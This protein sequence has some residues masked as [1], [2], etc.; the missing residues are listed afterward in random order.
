MQTSRGKS[1]PLG[2]SIG[3]DGVNFSVF[4]KHATAVELLLFDRIGDA[5]PSSVIPL[6]RHVNRTSDYW[7][8]CASGLSA[9]QLYGY[10]V[11]GP[12]DPE[13]GLRYDP[14][15]LLLD[16]YGMSVAC[17][18]AYSRSAASQPGPDFA[19]AMKSVVADMT[20]YDWRGDM[21]PAVPFQE[22]VIYEM[23]VAGFTKHPNSGVSPAKRGTYAGVIEKIP[24]LK[25]LGVTAVELL[26]VFQFDPQ[27]APDHLPNYWG[28]SPA[29]F[30]ALHTGYCS[31]NDPLV[32]LDEF[33]DMVRA[34]HSAGLEVIL[35]VVY[36]HTAEGGEDGPTLCFR[37]IENEVY[38][39]LERDMQHY[40][41]YTGCG[42]TLNANQAI[43]RRMIADS[44]KYW[45]EHM[46]IDGFRFDLAS[47]L[48]RDEDGT[49]LSGAPILADLDSDP[50]LAETK[51]IAEAW[52]AAGLYEVGRLKGD[53]WKEWNGK[54]RDDV[55]RFWKSDWDT[56]MLLPNRVLGS[57]DLY[58]HKPKECEKSINF[59]T[60]HDGFTL[61]DLVSYNEKHNEANLQNNLD[62]SNENYSWNCGAEGPTDNPETENLRNRQ[63]R[64]FFAFTLLSI[65]VPMF[66]MGDEVRRTQR[67]NNNPFCQDNEISWFDWTLV[68]KYADLR[69]FVNRLIELRRCFA[70]DSSQSDVNLTDFLSHAQLQWHG[71]RLNRPDW[72]EASH[73]LAMSAKNISCQRSVHFIWNAYWEPLTFELPEL[74]PIAHAK[75]SRLIDTSLAPPDDICLETGN[76]V[77]GETYQAAPRSTVLLVWD[78]PKDGRA[79]AGD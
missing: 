15:K 12:F 24:Y 55:R 8:M 9:G 32:C 5:T 65:G 44:V 60:C 34:L 10:R 30:F 61:N 43:V 31:K 29:S 28:Y 36:N 40:S 17:D 64:N 72:G 3:P 74:P 79:P 71:I 20:V 50:V 7:H 69:R 67:G 11:F 33:R 63:V 68:E 59:I 6:D 25:S 47:I 1:F 21:R 14:A 42:N 19:N 13:H 23:H 76:L 75:W 48:S 56:A 46:H 41:D 78:A 22:T 58:G 26:P 37:G 52:D 2:A 38:Y 45:V 54:F 18:N 16:P 35:D 57:P 49:P 53:N 77:D 27:D 39:I 62:G 66:V 4:S 70:L 51:L 73:S